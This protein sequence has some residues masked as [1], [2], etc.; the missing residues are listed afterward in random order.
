MHMLGKGGNVRPFLASTAGAPAFWQVDMLWV[1]LASGAQTGGRYSL[2]W[3]L[4]PKGAGPGPHTHEQDEALYVID[5][6]LAFRAAGQTIQAVA[7]AFLFIPRGVAHSFRVDSERAQLLNSYTP[8]GFERVI[9]EL[10]Q[11]ARARTLPPG[12]LPLAVNDA[13]RIADLFAQVGMRL[14]NE[15]DALRP[16]PGP[17]DALPQGRDLY[18]RA[19]AGE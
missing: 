8:A 9:M 13:R 15:P 17:Y 19:L 12:G 11:P 18:G 10:S 6:E 4:C 5:G 16:E 2:L 7:G 3:E 1:V 14:V